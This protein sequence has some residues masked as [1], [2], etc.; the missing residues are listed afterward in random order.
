M[1]PFFVNEMTQLV[2]VKQEAAFKL[3]SPNDAWIHG[4][5]I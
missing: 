2:L 3:T 5:E 1:N 4:L